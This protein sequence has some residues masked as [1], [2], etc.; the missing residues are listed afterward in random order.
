MLLA[1]LAALLCHVYP[2]A[3]AC[4]C[5]THFIHRR[6]A[7]EYKHSQVSLLKKRPALPEQTNTDSKRNSDWCGPLKASG[8]PPAQSRAKMKA[9]SGAPGP[10]PVK[11]W[12]PP[13]AEVFQPCFAQLDPVLATQ[14]GSVFPST[15]TALPMLQLVGS[16]PFAAYISAESAPVLDVWSTLLARAPL[17]PAHQDP[18]PPP[19]GCHRASP[20][21]CLELAQLL[22]KDVRYQA[23]A[24]PAL[25]AENSAESQPA[26]KVLTTSLPSLTGQQVFQPFCKSSHL[27]CISSVWLGGTTQDGI[28]SLA[29]IN[30]L[31]SPPSQS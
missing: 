14:L 18:G 15:Q 30:P 5:H 27:I 17:L 7:E 13:K 1:E 28:E 11:P 2:L 4:I 12:T 22:L 20:R 29:K 3:H 23:V 16:C 10:L 19:R 6:C 8:H 9:P 24:A 21:L 26:A 31:L 25:P